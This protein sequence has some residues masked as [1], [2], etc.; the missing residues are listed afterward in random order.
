MKV[1]AK[2]G[3]PVLAGRGLAQR[4]WPWP[5]PLRSPR[6]SPIPC[7]PLLSPRSSRR[8]FLGQLKCSSLGLS[9]FL[10][11]RFLLCAPKRAPGRGTLTAVAGG[12]AP[13]M[14]APSHSRLGGLLRWLVRKTKG[15]PS[16]HP[17]VN[18]E[19][20]TIYPDSGVPLSLEEGGHPD[21]GCNV[22]GPGGHCAQ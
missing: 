20:N 17:E 15:L 6:L 18:R 14:P 5:V 21:P 8:R 13:Q 2:T 10:G 9:H 19:Q 22:A 12:T 16:A 4:T 3:R 1:T 7:R 11:Q